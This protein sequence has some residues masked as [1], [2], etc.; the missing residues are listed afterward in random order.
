MKFGSVGLRITDKKME[1]GL[2][3]GLGLGF[4]KNTGW[5]MAY[6]PFRTFT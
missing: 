3:S 5:E 6:I 2:G 1:L 4:G